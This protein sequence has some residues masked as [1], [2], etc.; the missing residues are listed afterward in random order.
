[1]A[2]ILGKDTAT[3]AK[4]REGFLRDLQHFHETRGYV[5]Y[6]H[7]HTYTINHLLCVFVFFRTAFK[8]VPKVNGHEI[9]LYLLYSLVTQQGGWL[10]VSVDVVRGV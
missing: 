9:D 10:K 3:Y 7:T 2:K 8:R 6:Q 1:M 5:N 4:E